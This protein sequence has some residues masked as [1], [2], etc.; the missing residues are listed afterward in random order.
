MVLKTKINDK[1]CNTSLIDEGATHSVLNI[2]WYEHHGI[3]WRKEFNITPESE[4]GTML[5]ANQAPVPTHGTAR[6][7]ITLTDAKGKSFT[8]PFHLMSL[9][10]YNY[11]QILGIDWKNAL[12]V[13]TF[14][15]EYE[16]LIRALGVKVQTRAV[17]LK[18]HQMMYNPK[19]EP[20]QPIEESTTQQISKDIRLL[21]ARLR[22]LHINIPPTAS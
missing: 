17:P 20:I 14:N 9:G 21:S 15:P 22:R 12:K 7:K 4:V 10:K 5:M 1:H 11:A 8:F 13:V 6:V 16:L 3:D 18:I 2:D 19:E